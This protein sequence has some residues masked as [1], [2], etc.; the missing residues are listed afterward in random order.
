MQHVATTSEAP[1]VKSADPTIG[2]ALGAGGARGLSHIIVLEALDELGVRPSIIAGSSMGAIIG[3]GYAAGMS[4]KEIRDYSLNLADNRNLVLNRLWGLRP[5]SMRDALGGFRLG[6]FNLERILAA[7]L[8]EQIPEK[9][10]QL[11]VPLLTVSTD[12]YGQAEL[13]SRSGDLRLAVSASAAIPALFRPVTINGRL[14]IDGGIFNPVPYDHIQQDADI[15]IGVDVVGGPVGHVS[16]MPNRIDSLFGASQLMMQSNI[17][18]KLKLGAP[19]IFLRPNV[20][21]FRVLDFLKARQILE[22]AESL[23]DPFKRELDAKIT[24]RARH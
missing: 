9:F 11:S 20:N 2:L 8:P 1:E 3:S 15:I 17:A 10:E 12:Y 6:Q 4:G 18:L 16:Q 22:A 24:A 14:M 21:E 23:R 13:V 7:F 5:A 19:D